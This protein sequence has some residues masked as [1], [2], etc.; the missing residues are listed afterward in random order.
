MPSPKPVRWR[1]KPRKLPVDRY[2]VRI[3]QSIETNGQHHRL[4]HAWDIDD[5]GEEVFYFTH[6][7]L[8]GP[9]NQLQ[10]VPR[11]KPFT[12]EDACGKCWSDVVWSAP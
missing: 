5:T 2:G 7:E 10:F 4:H 8:M 12:T 3:P 1:I 11:R 6:C 9:A